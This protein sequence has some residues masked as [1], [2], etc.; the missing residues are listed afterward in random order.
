MKLTKFGHACVILEEQGQR[1][2]ID[3]G[4]FTTLPDD[5][6][7]VVAIVVT[8]EHPDHFSPDN[9]AAIFAQS[10]ESQLLTLQEIAVKMPDNKSKAVKPGDK[11]EAG[12]FKI[13][14]GGGLH[15]EIHPDLPRINN[16][17]VTINGSIYYPGDSYDAAAGQPQ[18][19]LL[20]LNAPWA[21]IADTVDF[22]KA[23]PAKTFIPTHNGLLTDNGLDIYHG[24]PRRTAEEKGAVLTSL[25][26][27]ESVEI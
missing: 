3:P 4:V 5:L 16:L 12:P 8:H 26:D 1:I 14:F 7:N 17:T 13:E 10:P 9:L 6:A 2:I 25:G 24:L 11:A 15:A 20:P 18:V 19:V 22:I 23:V 21:R 27:K